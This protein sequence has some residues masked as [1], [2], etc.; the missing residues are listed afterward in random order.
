MNVQINLLIILT[1]TL[2]FQ[3]VFAKDEEP[4]PESTQEQVIEP[5]I[6]RRDIN[7]SVRGA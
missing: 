7:A 2:S 4:E 1:L 6:Y 3:P 5:D